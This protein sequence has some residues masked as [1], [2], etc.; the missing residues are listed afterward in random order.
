MGDARREL[1][2]NNRSAQGLGLNRGGSCICRRRRFGRRGSRSDARRSPPE[3]ARF[4]V[5]SSVRLL[6]AVNSGLF[7][8]SQIGKFIT[9]I[10]ATIPTRFGWRSNWMQVTRGHP[11]P[12]VPSDRP[13]RP[14]SL[15]HYRYGSMIRRARVAD[16]GRWSR[17]QPRHA[18][19]R[20]SSYQRRS[21]STF[22][23]RPTHQ[24][25]TLSKLP[26]FVSR[27]RNGDPSSMGVIS[28]AT[29]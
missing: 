24:S 13:L 12:R 10:P 25:L 22:I 17:Q 26:E 14:G 15:V 27:R 18:R 21:T 28:S 4:K 6:G 3:G 7:G 16:R 20:R 19:P 8:I 9:S 11:A 5:L 23:D 2:A 29:P 1:S